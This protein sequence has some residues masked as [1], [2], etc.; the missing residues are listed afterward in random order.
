MS[1]LTQIIFSWFLLILGLSY[2]FQTENWIRLAGSLED[3][4][5]RFYPLSLMILVIGLLII[6]TH[7]I[8]VWRWPVAVTLLG[9][10]LVIKNT[11]YLVCTS[12]ID[13]IILTT[14]NLRLWLR[15]TGIVFSLLGIALVSQSIR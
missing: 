7:N 3:Q 10:L 1:E 5:Y 15:I 12:W 8:W 13:P 6:H 11:F 4:T 14:R 2:L 9:W